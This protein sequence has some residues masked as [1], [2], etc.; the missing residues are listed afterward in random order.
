[1]CVLFFICYFNVEKCTN[2]VVCL[3]KVKKRETSS[4]L[5]NYIIT[6]TAI[7]DVDVVKLCLIITM[8]ITKYSKCYIYSITSLTSII[9]LTSVSTHH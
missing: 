3:Q 8:L 6:I 5:F 2:L 1:M 4:L 7:L 9:Q